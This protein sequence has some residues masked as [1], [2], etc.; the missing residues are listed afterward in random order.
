MTPAQ[1][2]I[3]EESGIYTLSIDDLSFSVDA[4][5]GGRIISFKRAEKEMLIQKDVHPVYFGSTLWLSPQHLHW[6]PSAV[7][8]K[9]PYHVRQEGDILRLSSENDTVSGFQ[10][11]KE[12]GISAQDTSV[13]INYIIRNISGET[14]T[15]A[16]WDV[17]RVPGGISSFPLDEIIETSLDNTKIK[18]CILTYTF[19]EDPTPEKQKLFATCKEGRLMHQY[20][21]LLF[22]KIFPNTKKEELPPKQGCVEIFQAPKGQYAELENHGKYTT[23]HP[24]DSLEY[25]Q[26]WFLLKK[27]QAQ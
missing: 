2:I 25:K 13:T 21:G 22:I 18:G 26:Q 5:Y 10:F 17:S 9:D 11:I 4:K 15:V 14:K 1:K 16:A 6:P 8:D 24:G 23:L 12:F 20:N 3:A 7:L 27:Q 19:P